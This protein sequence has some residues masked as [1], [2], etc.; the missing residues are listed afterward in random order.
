MVPCKCTWHMA[1]V[2]YQA[3]SR[4]RDVYLTVWTRHKQSFEATLCAQQRFRP[5]VSK[6]V[7]HPCDAGLHA[8]LISQEPVRQ[9]MNARASAVGVTFTNI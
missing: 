3:T 1:M 7:D 8:Q 9:T 4:V 5:R 6:V 2:S